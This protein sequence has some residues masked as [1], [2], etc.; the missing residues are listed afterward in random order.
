LLGAF[1]LARDAVKGFVPGVSGL[2]PEPLRSLSLAPD[3]A[4]GWRLTA[5]LSDGSF[6][7]LTFAGGVDPRAWLSEHLGSEY[8]LTPADSAEVSRVLFADFLPPDLS[9]HDPHHE[10][11]GMPPP[12]E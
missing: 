6:A 3:L 7:D 8:G 5:A 1:I 12:G 4:A 11:Y 2:L 9:D 10:P